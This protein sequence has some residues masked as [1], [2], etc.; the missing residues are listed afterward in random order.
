MIGET[1][2]KHKRLSFE[3]MIDNFI[4][5]ANCPNDI[6]VLIV[7]EAQDCSKPQIEALK[8]SCNKC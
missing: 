4:F 6:D 3:D 2:P 7:D 5:N 8:K 1:N